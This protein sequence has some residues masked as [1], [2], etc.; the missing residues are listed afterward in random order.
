MKK[1]KGNSYVH[2][3]CLM[4]LFILKIIMLVPLYSALI[5]LTKLTPV[6][7]KTSVKPNK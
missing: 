2:L 4:L 6:T 7:E 3:G 5:D 1:N